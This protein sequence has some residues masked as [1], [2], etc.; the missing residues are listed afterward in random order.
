VAAIRRARKVEAG[1][2]EEVGRRW[3]RAMARRGSARWRPHRREGHRRLRLALGATGEDEGGEGGSKMENGGGFRG[4]HRG[5]G[6]ETVTVAFDGGKLGRGAAILTSEVG[7]LSRRRTGEEA[8]CL[9]SGERERSGKG[10]RADG[11][12]F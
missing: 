5:R 4:S 12:H 10:E 6:E 8:A 3:G 7:G 1:L 11:W 9:S 2:T